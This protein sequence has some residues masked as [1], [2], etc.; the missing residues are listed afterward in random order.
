MKD[1]KGHVIYFRVCLCV[2]ACAHLVLYV[3]ATEAVLAC[4]CVSV[5]VCSVFVSL[6]LCRLAKPPVPK[7]H[8]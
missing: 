6:S 2:Y 1:R 5:F 8:L 7:P 4:V 3:V